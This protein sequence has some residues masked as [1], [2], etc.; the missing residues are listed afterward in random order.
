MD[1]K[2]KNSTKSAK[3][4]SGIKRQITISKFFKK[5]VNVENQISKRSKNDDVDKSKEKDDFVKN[6]KKRKTSATSSK[7]PTTLQASDIKKSKCNP[8]HN[9]NL[10]IGE[11]TRSRLDSFSASCSQNRDVDLEDLKIKF[12]TKG[13]EDFDICNKTEENMTQE[14]DCEMESAEAVSTKTTDEKP[15]K[16]SKHSSITSIPG[17][18][19]PTTGIKYTPLEQQVVALKAKHPNTVLFIECGYKYR[20]FGED[21]EIAAKVLK[22]TCNPDHNFMTA[23]I[24]THRLLVHVK[25]LV[26]AGYKVGVVKQTETAALKA[27]SDN[28]SSVFT[29]HLTDLYTKSTLIEKDVLDHEETISDNCTISSQ[30]LMCICELPGQEKVK[31]KNLMHIGLVAIQ[32]AT[33]EVIY[34]CF[35][36]NITR[37]RL[38]TG[39]THLQPV[40]VILPVTLSKPTKDLFQHL[41]SI[42]FSDDDRMRI[43]NLNDDKFVYQTAFEN[44][45]TFYGDQETTDG[46]CHLQEVIRLPPA[47]TCCLSAL[48]DYLSDFKLQKILKVTSYFKP[49]SLESSYLKL[50]AKT[51]QNLELFQ[52]LTTRQTK[53]SLFWVLDHTTTSFG[54]RLL[55]SWVSH[56]LLKIRDI[57]ERQEAIGE[58]LSNHCE[59]FSAM[60]ASLVKLP[61][62]EKGLV[63]IVYKKCTPL[64]FVSISNSLQKISEEYHI[65]KNMFLKDVKSQMLKEIV[66][67]IP[68]LLGDI[69]VFSNALNLEALKSNNKTNLFINETQFPDIVEQ[70]SAIKG[71]RREIDEYRKTVQQILKVPS[72]TYSTVSGVEF[73][74]EVKNDLMSRVPQDWIKIS[75]TK[76]VSR[77]HSPFIEEKYK[78]LNQRNEQLEM[79]CNSAWIEFLNSFQVKYQPYKKAVHLLATLDCLFSLAKATQ[80]GDYVRPE[81]VAGETCV[82]IEQGRNP[83]VHMLLGENQQYVPNET[84]LKVGEQQVMIIT[85]PNMGGKSSYIRQVALIIIMAQIGSYIPAQTGRLG[86]FDAIYTRMGAADDIFKG[87]STFMV[88]LQE[89]AEIIHHATAKSLVILDE[90]GRGTSTHDGLAIADATLDFFIQ[91]TKCIT[92]F[93]THYQV[94]CHFQQLYPDLVGNYHMSFLI[95]EDDTD[96]EDYEAVTFL[97]QLVLGVA[98]HSYGLNVASLAGV[99]TNILKVA[100]KKSKQLQQKLDSKRKMK[101]DFLEIFHC[102]EEQ[103]PD[104]VKG[105]VE[106]A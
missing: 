13:P 73:L 17:S 87:R 74:I 78:L 42:S 41:T 89:A 71:I 3:G 101:A 51:V 30:Y 2:P 44:I 60:K 84:H 14:S 106:T 104:L 49:F 39:I 91:E 54:K 80:N 6:N 99:K 36:D 16:G 32:P 27:A 23:S 53:G 105:L 62:L 88:E 61:D 22:I 1:R 96:S 10:G 64:E 68:E 37:S 35:D 29:R 69:G 90:L 19:K 76:A 67:E 31:G 100:S 15:S 65:Q 75:S 70:K 34:D 46:V 9:V 95:N 25:R 79:A 28:K 8:K 93:V 33:G 47:V 77:F 97:Y 11:I 57:E 5:D 83:I 59:C 52:N 72:F 20:F 24:P 82:N 94:L 63:T 56:P 86:I 66:D 50:P 103:L 85:G 48:I 45:T 4:E 81:L 18:K 40:E 98:S 43:E 102:P 38:E 12:Q 7:C 58:L 55:H 26:S 21:A 92:L